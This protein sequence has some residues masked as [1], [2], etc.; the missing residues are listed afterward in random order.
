[1]SPSP[2]ALR[3]P[4]FWVALVIMFM[5]FLGDIGSTL[6]LGGKGTVQGL[7]IPYTAFVDGLLLFIV[8]VTGL[9]LIVSANIQGKVH[10]ILSLIVSLVVIILGIMKIIVAFLLLILMLSLLL[11]IPF[12]TLIYLAEFGHFKREAAAVVLSST[13]GLKFIFIVLLV[14]AHQKFLKNKGLVLLTLT[15]L[16]CGVIISFLHGFV[17]LPLVSITD[18]LAA[19][20]VALLGVIWAILFLILSIPSIVR[21]V[22]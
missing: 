10:G 1:M 22:K 15:S 17:P 12:G 11:A 16:L 13:M 2:G 8:I 6:L 4:F 19:I 18:A 21:A 3:A 9:S 20:V 14:L 7:G 5:I